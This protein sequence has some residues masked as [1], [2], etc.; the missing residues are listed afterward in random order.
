MKPSPFN[1]YRANSIEQA[2]S[3]LDEHGDDAEVLAGG[4]SLMAMLN[5]RLL[6]PEALIDINPIK[7]LQGI[8]AGDALVSTS[9]G[10]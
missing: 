9:F 2:L 1:Y 8:S 7:E 6:A 5:L 4:Q 3:L 10:V